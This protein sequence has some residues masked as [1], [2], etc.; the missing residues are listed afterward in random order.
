MLEAQDP[1][2]ISKNL[3]KVPAVKTENVSAESSEVNFQKKSILILS[4][5]LY[6]RLAMANNRQ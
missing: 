1:Y 2:I 3:L 4:I 5:L 6:E